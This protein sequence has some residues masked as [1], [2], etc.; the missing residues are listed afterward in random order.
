MGRVLTNNTG[1]IYSIESALGTA[2]TTWFTL[3]PNSINSWGATITTVAREPISKD[4]QRRKGTLTDLDSAMEFEA[5]WTVSAFM[6]FIEGFVFVTG[7]NR[8][9]DI[10]STAAET[11]GDSYTVA[12]LTAAQA[13]KLEF[14]A[15]EYATLIFARGFAES[16]NNGLK[17]LDADI[18]T[19]A[20]SVSV[21]ENLVD[22]TAPA[23]AQIEL[24]GIRFLDGVT[25]ITVGYSGTTLTITEGGTIGS[26]DFTTLGLTV[27]QYIHIGSAT[28][29]GGAVQNALQDS[30]ANDT[31]G[32]ARIKTIAALVITC[33]K[34]STDLQVASP[35]VPS[36]LDILFGKFVRN[37]TVDDSEYL[38]RSFQFEAA[39]ENL[40]AG[41]T[42]EFEYSIGN[43]ANQVSFALP[44][45]SKATT[46]FGFIGTDTEV[47]V[48]SGSRKSG[49]SAATDPVM[50]GALNT[51]SDVARLRVQDTDETGLTTDFKDITLTLDNQVSPE[52]I[53]GT[54]GAAYMNTGNFLVNMQMQ[55]LF[56]DKDVVTRIRQNT[57]VTMDFIV[58]NDDGAIVVDI[59]SMTIGDGSRELPVNE[60]VLITMAGEAFKDE[61]L[62]Y[63]LGVSVFPVVPVAGTD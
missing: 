33:D 32:Y 37:V 13:G 41:S 28:S 20:T 43:F 46:T 16:G 17:T 27:G 45:T 2:G 15:A 31:F 54:L 11:T 50:T 4:R 47:P 40:G 51:S 19:S 44:L 60:S 10:L 18:A 25:D 35:T 58:Q 56:T 21:S 62:D 34:V 61:T 14:S 57:T 22:E 48:V 52:K 38:E 63:S 1:F 5:D 7:V 39:W 29:N 24:A 23:N 59:P 3:E 30:V 36:T 53:L 8:D 42:D 49:A 6:D 9:M 12:A 55:A 26:W